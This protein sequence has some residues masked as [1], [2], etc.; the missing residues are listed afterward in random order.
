MNHSTVR[1]LIKDGAIIPNG[2]LVEDEVVTLQA[3]SVGS[4]I[5]QVLFIT[6]DV[7]EWWEQ[8]NAKYCGWRY[9]IEEAYGLGMTIDDMLQWYAECEVFTYFEMTNADLA[10]ELRKHGRYDEEA[11]RTSIMSTNNVKERVM[12]MCDWFRDVQEQ[13]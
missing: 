11:L 10:R 12:Y 7:P 4:E 6:N 5:T 1:K 8:A 3:I 13:A 2:W 9:A